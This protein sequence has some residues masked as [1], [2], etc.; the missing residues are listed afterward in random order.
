MINLDNYPIPDVLAMP[1]YEELL[2][3]LNTQF[4]ELVPDYVPL[5][6]DPYQLLLQSFAYR[7]LHFRAVVN[8]RLR[9]MLMVFASGSDLD[10]VALNDY[11]LE[12]L[13]GETDRQFK[14]RILRSF[15]GFSTAGSE[16]SYEYHAYSVSADI[17]DVHA[18]SPE[19]GVV[20]VAIASNQRVIDEPLRQR[21]ATHLSADKIRPL[22]DTVR[23]V[24]AEQI[25]PRIV[26]TLELYNVDESDATVQNAI[27]NFTSVIYQIGTDLPLSQMIAFLHVPNVYRVRLS[28]PTADVICRDDQV[29]A[30]SPDQFELTVEEA[31][32][33]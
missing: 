24:V 22:T 9:S 6:S 27:H 12:R 23:V 18:F 32:D 10:T 20:T 13:E 33:E 7:E 5:D 8:A 4:R 3:E 2:D 1:S 19:K 14:E 28:Q 29:L 26:A 25:R 21:V 15:D 16:Q 11:Q 30:F 31:V 17:H